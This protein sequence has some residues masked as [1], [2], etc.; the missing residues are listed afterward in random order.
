M[1]AQLAAV[2]VSVFYL[3]LVIGLSILNPEDDAPETWPIKGLSFHVVPA[4][5]VAQTDLPRLP[6]RRS[7]GN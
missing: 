4:P 7:P 5:C 6:G 3:W 2:A 1:V